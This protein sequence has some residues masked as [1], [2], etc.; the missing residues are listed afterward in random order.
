MLQKNFDI[1][2]INLNVLHN[3]FDNSIKLLYFQICIYI[4][5]FLNI[6]AKLHSIYVLFVYES[7]IW[8]KMTV[9]PC[10]FEYLHRKNKLNIK[11]IK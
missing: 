3:Y 11:N 6:S 9:N 1:L 2:T 4:A 5:K 8:Y 7:I 10:N